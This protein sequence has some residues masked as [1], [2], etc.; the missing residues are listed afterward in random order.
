MKTYNYEGYKVYLAQAN[1]QNNGRLAVQ[2]F[3]AEDGCPFM[4]VSV[5]LPDEE[6]TNEKSTFVKNY[7]ENR[8]VD[9][10][11]IEN[12]LAHYTGRFNFQLGVPE[13][14]FHLEKF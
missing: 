12:D 5:N 3:D 9:R 1:Y 8:G 4:T 6:V 7:S 11:L 10:W 2:M 14:E 13:M